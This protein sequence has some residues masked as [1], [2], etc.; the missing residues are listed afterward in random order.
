MSRFAV[1]SLV[2]GCGISFASSAQINPEV[3]SKKFFAKDYSNDHQAV[4]DE[5]YFFD[6]PY[7]A[8]QDHEDYDKDFVKDE[9]NDNGQWQAQMEYDAL[10]V[11]VT[12]ATNELKALKKKLDEQTAEMNAA[13]D[14]WQ[15][16]LDKVKAAQAATD[17]AKRAEVEADGTVNERQDEVKAAQA[18]TDAAKRAEV[19]A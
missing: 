15:E 8:V 2:F 1:I 9:N 17:A 16:A 19:E 6:H 11:K 18:A 13:R 3:S 14:K 4:A 5:H 7:P 12:Q 10:R